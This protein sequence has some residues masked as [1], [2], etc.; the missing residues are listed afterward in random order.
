[1][2]F[3]LGI[4]AK[5]RITG[6]TGIITAHAVWLTGCDTYLIQPQQVKEGEKPLDSTWYDEGRV[7]KID[8]G[9][10]A[11]EVESKKTGGDTSAIPTERM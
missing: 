3:E 8:D 9:I 7:E 2:K 1:M 11:I 6:V 10:N 5:D 4:K